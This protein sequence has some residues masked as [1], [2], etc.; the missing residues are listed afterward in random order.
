EGKPGL[1]RSRLPSDCCHLA[2]TPSRSHNRR[3]TFWFS[4][5][6]VRPWSRP[7]RSVPHSHHSMKLLLLLRSQLVLEA[8]GQAKMQ[9][10]DFAFGIKD[11]VQLTESQLFIDRIGFHDRVQR[12]H[13]VL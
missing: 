12:F 7:I 4:S 6:S 3:L 9:T 1:L 11:L 2:N 13:R 8:D 5:R 10:L